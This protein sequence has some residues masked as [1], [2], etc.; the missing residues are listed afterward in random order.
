MLMANDSVILQVRRHHD[1]LDSKPGLPCLF[2]D[3]AMAARCGAA[4]PEVEYHFGK[5]QTAVGDIE[6]DDMIELTDQFKD[7]AGDITNENQGNENDALS[8]NR[9][10]ANRLG[11]GKRPAAAKADQHHGLEDVRAQQRYSIHCLSPNLRG[12]VSTW[13]GR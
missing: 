13:P 8:L 3:T 4:V 7:D 2:E 12:L 5:H 6:P 9:L 1:G 11:D 10:G